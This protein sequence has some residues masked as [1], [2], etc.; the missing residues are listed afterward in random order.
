MILEH[1][2][3]WTGRLELLKDYYVKYF[4]AVANEKYTNEKKTIS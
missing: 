2:A 3:I 4:G 1:V